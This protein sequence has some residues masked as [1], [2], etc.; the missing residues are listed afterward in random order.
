MTWRFRIAKSFHFSILD[1]HLVMEAI[2]KILKRH[3]LTNSTNTNSGRAETWWEALGRC[4]D[5]ELLNLFHSDIQD[6]RHGGHF[7]ILQTSSPPKL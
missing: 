1:G 7:E 5:S 6:G 2:L 4:G 3:L